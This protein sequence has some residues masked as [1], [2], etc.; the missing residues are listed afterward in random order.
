MATDTVDMQISIRGGAFTSDP[1]LIVFEG[2]T[3]SFPNPASF[4]D[5]LEFVAG[6][7]VVEVRSIS[8]S[9]AVST[10][11]R[12][13][14]TLVQESDIG[15]IGTTPTNI[16]VEQ[17]RDEVEIRIEG[18]DDSTFQG[19]N[20]YASRFQGGGAT[21]YQRI[22]VN[23]ITDFEA[24]QETQEI[25][26]LQVDNPVARNPDGTPAAD[27]LFVKIKETQTS[28][29]DVIENL[30][31][32]TLTPELAAAIT[33]QEQ[34]SL[35][36]TDFVEVFEVP[37]TTVTIRSNYSV[38]S[39]VARNFY[40]F[41]HNRQFGAGNTPPTVPIGDFAAAPLT[42]PLFY[43]A[44]AL[45]FDPD[46]QLEVESSFSAEVVARPVVIN[47]NVGTFPAP[48]RLEI[49]QNTISS[50][51]RTTPQVAIQP[52]AVIRDT[53]VDPLSSEASRLRLLVDFLYRIQSFDTLLQIDGIEPDGT[54]TPVA[55]SP[56]KQALGQ[57]FN[58]TNPTE[59]QTLIDTTFE[60]LASRNNVFR[61]AG[62]RSTGFV[63]FFT[64]TT[65][66]ATIFIPLGSRVASGSV[67]YATTTDRSI[68]IN[69]V[70]AFFNPSTGLFQVDAPVQAETPGSVGDL[71][72]G[73]IRT[74]VSNLPGL[75]VTNRN[76]TFG[77]TDQETNLQLSVRARNALASV[78]SGTEQ[79][80]LQIA[81]DVAG[82]IEAA[83]IA[84]GEDM[85]QRDFDTDFDKHVGG[86]VD[87]WV[88]GDAF[89]D[90][91]DSFAFT[92]EV[93]RDVQFQ[94]I[95]NPLAYQLR[96][97]DTQLSP[98]NPIAQMLD[99]AE[100]GLGL[101]N[102]TRG[103]FFDLTD[104][105]ILDYRTIQLDTNVVQPEITFGDIILG[106]YRYVASTKFVFPRQPV[107]EVLSVTGTVSGLLPEDNWLFVR[108][109]DPLIEGR[110]IRAQAFLEIV[111]VDGVP[112]GEPITVTSEQHL[113]LGEF[114][115]FVNNLGA[116]PLTIQVF[117]ST[118]TII[119]RGPDDPSGIADYTITPGTQT[120]ALS[121]R[122]TA[123]SAITSGETVL[124]DYEHDENFT[125]EYQTNFV[126]PTVQD[127]L[128]AQKHL[129]ADLL[130]KA[131]VEI[132]VDITATVVVIAGATTSTVDT[133][134][135]T[136]IATFLRALPQGA[137]VRPSDIIAVMDNTLDV[138]FI[139]T[140]LRKITRGAGSLAVRE[141]VPST[142]GEVEVL[143]GTD[144]DPYSTSTVK[145]W[146][147]ENPLNNPTTQGGGDGTQFT[148]VFQDDAAMVL[149]LTNPET[150]KD[151]PG[152]AF[153][154]GDAGQV[155]PAFSD[156]ATIQSNF[157]EANTAA[158][159]E[160]IR[161][162]LTANRILVSLAAD[163]RPEIH[164][165]T[166]TYTVAFVEVRVQDIEASPLEFFDVGNLIF[167]F[168]EDQHGV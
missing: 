164:A 65:P 31:D 58:L 141:S 43:V 63:T 138:S 81:A 95:G 103:L 160:Q 126:I 166:T 82:V 53:F 91:T 6:L 90:V 75:S 28:S 47:E 12:V 112:S 60:Q 77:G 109:D 55:R 67:Q 129:T 148:G 8:F 158:E 139:E 74:I 83:V 36:R 130:G 155:I 102:A 114:E 89:G 150:L 39:L 14:V 80:T 1:D 151:A 71:G 69:N 84:A 105:Q 147:L 125:V 145:T 21:G 157:P 128:D 38:S 153:I 117:N 122:R 115:E 72:A 87:V 73:Q 18:V 40:T 61:K 149:Q 113:L 25:G 27:P 50:I 5:G 19:I 20:F 70:A 159:I 59:I 118:A 37:E 41:L 140:P 35:L 167:T 131:A 3:F 165:Y 46:T 162:N 142:A 86:K 68:P 156:D 15:L 26:S 32:I 79:G 33:E 100:L 124:L 62:T 9:G 52:G 54:S 152:R 4:P 133:D 137:A 143:L 51:T 99:D 78:D 10:S 48:S 85:M 97:L 119:Y 2:D 30:E 96:A 13:Q 136:N 57:V 76:A 17:L 146:L 111:Q 56:Y 7:N 104:V 127:S 135:R 163:D 154:I 29:S 168:T 101:R 107:S 161:R 34:A 22:N 108:P 64:R 42:E 93:A 121:I 66:T 98:T 144:A 134:L 92:F 123:N 120:T 132:P 45:F 11:A 16:S 94:I 110:S 24:V 49:V 88:R 106:D 116:N 44:T 23:T